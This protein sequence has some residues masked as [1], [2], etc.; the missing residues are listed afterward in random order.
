[1]DREQLNELPITAFRHIIIKVNQTHSNNI[2]VIE[3]FLEEHL[4]EVI[5]I[6]ACNN[7]VSD[8]EHFHAL[9]LLNH[10]YDSNYIKTIRKIFSRNL[11]TQDH[12]LCKS[13]VSAVTAKTYCK[14]HNAYFNI[15]RIKS[16]YHL[17]NVYDYINEKHQQDWELFINTRRQQ[18][19]RE[20]IKS[21]VTSAVESFSSDTVIPTV[22]HVAKNWN[23]YIRLLSD[24]ILNNRITNSEQLNGLAR[25]DQYVSDLLLD[26]LPIGN[27]TKYQ[28]ICS[29]LFEQNM[30]NATKD[31]VTAAEHFLFDESNFKH[32]AAYG[33]IKQTLMHSHC[34]YKLNDE[35]RTTQVRSINYDKIMQLMINILLM[36]ETKKT[37]IILF[38]ATNAGKSLLSAV[39][40]SVFDPYEIGTCELNVSQRDTFWADDLP[41]KLFYRVEEAVV[42]SI[43]DLNMMKKLCE[44]NKCLKANRKYKCKALVARRPTV[45]TFNGDEIYDMRGNKDI[46]IADFD[47]IFSRALMLYMPTVMTDY[48]NNT[49]IT[50]MLEYGKYAINRLIQEYKDTESLE[51]DESDLK[52]S[53]KWYTDSTNSPSPPKS[54]PSSPVKSPIKPS[55]VSPATSIV[56]SDDEDH[57][58]SNSETKKRVH[59]K[60]FKKAFFAKRQK[61]DNVDT[62]DL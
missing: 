25:Q 15:R 28:S 32:Q 27:Q 61:I 34:T 17:I 12:S 8:N 23:D 39:L 24:V 3:A 36:K 2:E 57:K 49:E 7:C 33:A 53:I 16:R 21:S 38:G 19:Y 29:G 58:P 35:L 31:Y 56:L 44:G 54:K 55:G 52:N 50:V 43:S 4:G 5:T 62:L 60:E 40:A 30:N 45:I 37:S 47:P 41:G 1:M 26:P 9:V 14:T 42:N 11:S 6:G 13:C 20:S 59:S 18:Q 48:L 10:Q 51:F 22:R 46:D